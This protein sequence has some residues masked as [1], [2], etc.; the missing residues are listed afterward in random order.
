MKII[1]KLNKN[2]SNRFYGNKNTAHKRIAAEDYDEINLGKNGL[3]GA[4][5]IRINLEH[6]VDVIEFSY[7][8]NGTLKKEYKELE[9]LRDEIE[10]ECDAKMFETLSKVLSK[11]DVKNIKASSFVDEVVSRLSSDI[12]FAYKKWICKSL[13][14]TDHSVQIYTVLAIIIATVSISN[15]IDYKSPVSIS[16]SKRALSTHIS[17]KARIRGIKVRKRDDFIRIPKIEAK[18][19][20][21]NAL[22]DETG[23]ESSFKLAGHTLVFNYKVMDISP[24]VPCFFA[25]EDEEARVFE[26]LLNA[27]NPLRSYPLDDDYE[28]ADV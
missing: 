13:K 19:E 24:R 26:E 8:K 11:K 23:V 12:R 2:Q 22:C 5:L 3:Q 27:F 10:L 20:Y 4:Q 1:N 6:P 28:E 7:F 25:K 21:L 16:I 14:N 9:T 17:V 18:L 15:N